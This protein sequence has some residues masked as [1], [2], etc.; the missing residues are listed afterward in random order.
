MKD[1]FIQALKSID[2]TLD[3]TTVA[4]RSDAETPDEDDER[5][6]EVDNNIPNHDNAD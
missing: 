3:S 5:F 6:A 4:V 1:D 2:P